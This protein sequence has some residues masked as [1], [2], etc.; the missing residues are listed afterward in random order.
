MPKT[1]QQAGADRMDEDVLATVR[2]SAPRR[3]IGIGMLA[4]IGVLVIYVAVVTPPA[5]HWRLFLVAVG[6]LALWMADRMRRAT[7][8]AIE[9]TPTELR[10]SSGQRIALIA[11]IDSMDRGF[12]AFKPSHGFLVKTRSPGLRIWRPGM[13]WRIGR[14]IGVGGVTPGSQ[15]K[16]MSEILAAMLAMRDHDSQ[17]T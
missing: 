4:V 2:A 1:A 11:D 13:W 15:T 16:A 8:F 5:P 3:W 14:R 7:E 12:F 9:L 6:V 10:D 17:L